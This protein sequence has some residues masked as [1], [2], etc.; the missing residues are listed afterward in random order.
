MGLGILIQTTTDLAGFGFVVL[1]FCESNPI[2]C[3]S[4]KKKIFVF[5][6]IPNYMADLRYRLYGLHSHSLDKMVKMLLDTG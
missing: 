3:L 4:R 5:F 1:F 2:L 6:F